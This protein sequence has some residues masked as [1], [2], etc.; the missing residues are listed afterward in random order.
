MSPLRASRGSAIH[1][2]LVIIIIIYFILLQ[3]QLF[4]VDLSQQSLHYNKLRIEIGN[5]SMTENWVMTSV[6]A[7]LTARTDW[8][9]GLSRG[10]FLP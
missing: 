1:V 3:G 6:Y 4:L 9:G 5:V 10:K 7:Q 2:F 8:Q